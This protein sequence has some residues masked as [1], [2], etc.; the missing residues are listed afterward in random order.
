MFVLSCLS[1]VWFFV[2]PW[3]AAC[4]APLSSSTPRVCSDSCPL[5]QWCYLTISSSAAR[6][7]FCLQSFPASG[8][9]PMSQLFPSGSQSI[10]AS[11]SASVLPFNL[12]GWFP[13]G[14]WL[15]WSFSIPKKSQESSPGPQL[16]SITSLT[17]SLLLIQLSHPFMTAGK[18]IALSIHTFVDS[19][20]S[21]F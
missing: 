11:T 19:Y 13:L 21:A 7:S 1:H 6:F 17:L 4:Q 20:T 18:I 3:A 14:F 2:A 15:L 16:E 8:S 10:G 5:S 9:F 12:Q